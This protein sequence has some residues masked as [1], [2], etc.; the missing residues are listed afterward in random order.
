MKQVAMRRSLSFILAAMFL[1]AGLTV[2]VSAER[3]PAIDKFEKIEGS[4]THEYIR[5]EK[6]EY[7][8]DLSELPLVA[9]KQSS[10]YLLIWTH[11]ELGDEREAVFQAVKGSD[12]ALKKM[13]I[14]SVHFYSGTFEVAGKKNIGP[15]SARLV[16]GKL[17]MFVPTDKVSHF[18]FGMGTTT[19]T[20]PTTT[21]TQPTTTT[22]QPTTTITQ[23]TTTTTQPTTTTTQ[24]TTTTTQSTT[25]TTQP[26]TTTTQSTT[27]TTQSTMTTTQPTTTTTQPTTTTTQPTTTTTQPTTTTTQPTT[28]TTQPTTTTTQPTTTTTQPT[29]TTT[30]PT[31]VEEEEIEDPTIPLADPSTSTSLVTTVTTVEELEELEDPTIPLTGPKTGDSG[32]SWTWIGLLLLSGAMVLMTMSRAQ[33]KE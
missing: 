23:S 8:I 25:T 14:S 30:Q 32:V 15:Y 24:P 27:T 10:D 13:T 18:I 11:E 16:D 1:I 12:A 22:T 19:T 29:T 6:G 33:G 28:T 17:Y 26:T 5:K 9:I 21:T 31:T 7:V 2:L 3:L 4:F 20:Q